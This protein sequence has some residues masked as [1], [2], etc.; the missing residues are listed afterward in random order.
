MHIGFV[1]R[2]T[3]SSFLPLLDAPAAVASDIRR[4]NGHHNTSLT[5]LVP[6]LLARGHQISLF[7]AMRGVHQPVRLAGDRLALYLVPHRKIQLEPERRFYDQER[8]AIRAAIREAGPDLLH[9]HW[10]DDGH[11]SAALDSGLPCL[12][13]ERGAVLSALWLN[14][15]FLPRSLLR[16]LAHLRLTWDV[17]RRCRHLAAVSPILAE[18]LRR[19]YRY[20]GPIELLPN[21]FPF[22]EWKAWRMPGRRAYDPA[23]PHFVSIGR[24]TRLKNITT[25]IRA[26]ARLRSHIPG[27]RLSLYGNGLGQD[28]AGFRWAHAEGLAPGIAFRGTL[29]YADLMRELARD[30]DVMVHLSREE[31]SCNAVC[32]ALAFDIPVIAGRVGAIPWAV[33]PVPV[34]FVRN[35]ADP[36]E[37]AEAMLR[38]ARDPE[39]GRPRGWANLLER[40]F[41]PAIAADQAERIYEQILAG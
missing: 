35:V 4:L 7:A 31:S 27:A 38:L 29:P 8:A 3:P 36:R 2:L 14:R 39:T 32:E 17:C 21:P 20:P 33:A 11:A 19:V 9:A 16:A 5:H 37:A 13:T 30:A 40:R 12:V 41:S 25:L 26:F 6:P 1:S 23:R 15:Q 10:T 22:E 18:H 34:T 28:Q 24:W